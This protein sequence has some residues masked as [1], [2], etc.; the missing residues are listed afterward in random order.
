MRLKLIGCILFL[1]FS[2]ATAF[3]EYTYGASNCVADRLGDPPTN[4]CTYTA[5]YDRTY[6][7]VP[8]YIPENLC[9]CHPVCY[10]SP[11]AK[12]APPG[13]GPD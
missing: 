8:F 2:C 3:G 12:A 13:P 10:N 9:Y 7:N 6:C 5:L 4:T 11:N 1:I